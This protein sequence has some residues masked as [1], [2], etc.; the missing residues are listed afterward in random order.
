VLSFVR[1]VLASHN[2][3]LTLR[4]KDKLDVQLEVLR[5]EAERKVLREMEG[6]RS[7]PH[8]TYLSSTATGHIDPLIIK[9]KLNDARQQL[10]SACFLGACALF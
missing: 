1:S 4:E 7:Q 8:P 6:M 2:P 3:N 9:V 5:E 10:L